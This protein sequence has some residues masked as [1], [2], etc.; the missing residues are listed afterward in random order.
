MLKLIKKVVAIAM[1]STFIVV[2]PVGTEKVQGSE[3]EF[4]GALSETARNYKKG[5][6]DLK[7]QIPIMEFLE[8]LKQNISNLELEY[9]FLGETVK[10]KLVED[11]KNQEYLAVLSAKGGEV[12]IYLDNSGMA[13]NNGEQTFTTKGET[14]EEFIKWGTGEEYD[15]D[16]YKMII[17]PQGLDYDEIKKVKLTY[18]DLLKLQSKNKFHQYKDINVEKMGMEL[19]KI[20]LGNIEL[21]SKEK[22]TTIINEK[23]LEIDLYKFNINYEEIE[24]AVKKALEMDIV[25][26]EQLF[27]K[28]EWYK[29]Y[30]MIREKTSVEFKV[31]ENKII[32]T[33]IVD[34]SK[35][36]YEI[37]EKETIIKSNNIDN[38]LKDITITKKIVTANNPEVEVELIEKRLM[39][40]VE[41]TER[42]VTKERYPTDLEPITLSTTIRVKN[43]IDED[44]KITFEKTSNYPGSG[45]KTITINTKLRKDNVRVYDYWYDMNNE[46]A[47][48]QGIEKL[49]TLYISNYEFILDLNYDF[50]NVNLL[51]N[52]TNTLG[53]IPESHQGN[54]LFSFTPD[55]V[56][57][58]IKK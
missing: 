46:K 14:L 34:K 21:V 11:V 13:I 17:A 42:G 6:T 23:E 33:T 37:Q 5:L 48:K 10:I 52:T 7:G 16:L 45:G 4:I 20:F 36:Y 25:K 54:S 12:T 24:K 56:F 28:E 40:E 44:G 38:L 26:K 2:A 30:K 50:F 18:S 57:E 41:V 3:L 53:N 55:E 47:E 22:S 32:E 9:S 29:K 15:E 51:V 1:A 31:F 27:E 39:M 8:T 43:T 19:I 35:N 58:K 49:H